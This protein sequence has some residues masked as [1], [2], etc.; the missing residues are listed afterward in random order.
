VRN[1]WGSFEWKGDLSDHS[2]KWTP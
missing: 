1:P 2:S